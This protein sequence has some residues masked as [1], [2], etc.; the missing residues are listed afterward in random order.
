MAPARGAARGACACALALLLVLGLLVPTAVAYHTGSARAVGDAVS[1][2]VNL[3][4]NNWTG[5]TFTIGSGDRL[6]YDIRVTSGTA[7]DMYIVPPDGL[8]D[9][10][11]DTALSFA[12]YDEVENRMTITGTHVGTNGNAG[13]TTVIVDNVDFSGATPTGTVRVS[14]NLT[15]TISPGPSLLLVAGILIGVVVVI[16]VVA[17]LVLKMRKKPPAAV[18][19]MGPPPYPGTP[20]PYAPPPPYPPPQYP[21]PPYPPQGPYPPPP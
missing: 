1:E 15:R 17:L 21:P 3:P 20:G 2:T 10:E 9:Y 13:L 8:N 11:S 12:L 6:A 19:P 7:I 16:A 5:Y 18:P 14:V 4:I